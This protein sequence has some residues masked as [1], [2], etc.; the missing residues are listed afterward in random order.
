MHAIASKLTELE[1][2]AVSVYLSGKL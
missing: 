2:R 1:M